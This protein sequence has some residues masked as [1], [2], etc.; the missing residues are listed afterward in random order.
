MRFYDEAK[1]MFSYASHIGR[2][3]VRLAVVL[4]TG[5]AIE[6]TPTEAA[7]DDIEVLSE[8]IRGGANPEGRKGIVML[9]RYDSRG[10]YSGGCTGS[11]IGPTLV[12][13]A[14]HCIKPNQKIEIYYYKPGLPANAPVLISAGG[15]R[16]HRHP[17]FGSEG[18]EGDDEYSNHDVGLIELTGA[19]RWPETTNNDYLL[20]YEGQPLPILCF[21]GQGY[22]TISGNG[23]GELS[24]ATFNLPDVKTWR[25]EIGMTSSK[26]LCRGDSGGPAM[27][28]N[29]DLIACIT[30]QVALDND[31]CGQNDIIGADIFDEPYALC[32]R[33][34]WRNV[35]KFVKE[36]TGIECVKKSPTTAAPYEHFQCF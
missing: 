2:F 1:I 14:A 33:T 28:G 23:A 19:T 24:M 17:E 13:T 36:A 12:L 26:G 3:I 35:R 15:N 10:N 6:T 18:S 30:S 29:T 11:L 27:M 32:S 8:A 34:V 9:V 7:V 22:Q 4:M 25:A 20:I 21:Y 31:T 5:C 16:T